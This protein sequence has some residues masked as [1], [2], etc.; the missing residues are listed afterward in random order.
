MS[1]PS[2]SRLIPTSTSNTPCR[3]SRIISMRSSVSISECRY[4]TL[5]P[6]SLRYSVKSSAIFF[7]SVVTS[8]RSPLAITLRHSAIKSSTWSS[9]GLTTQTGSISPVG[10]ITCSANTPWLCSSSQSPGVAETKIVGARNLSHSSNF[11][12]R[13]PRTTAAGT[14][15]QPAWICGCGRRDTCRRFAA[16]KC[17]SR[18]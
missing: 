14:R 17:G 16:P 12:G 6:F 11:N 9:T 3:R 8:A 5:I 10:R 4:R 1:S 15:N 18:Q 2:R 7:V 13:C